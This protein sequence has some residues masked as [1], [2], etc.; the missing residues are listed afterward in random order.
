MSRRPPD[1]ILATCLLLGTEGLFDIEGLLGTDAVCAEPERK[2]FAEHE[3][4]PSVPVRPSVPSQRRGPVC[5][6]RQEPL[7]P[8]PERRSEALYAEPERGPFLP[9]LRG[10]PAVRG[11]PLCG[12]ERWPSMPSL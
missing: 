10:A 1:Q 6:A 7:R 11:G 12:A 3:R 2:P 9:S 4:R 5:P 8:E